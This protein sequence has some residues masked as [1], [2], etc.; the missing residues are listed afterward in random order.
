MKMF[1]ILI[2]V[3][4]SATPHPQGVNWLKSTLYFFPLK[5]LRALAPFN[6]DISG[7]VSDG[8][9]NKFTC[10]IKLQMLIVISLLFSFEAFSHN[11]NYQNIVLH[12]WSLNDNTKIKASFLMFKNEEVYLQKENAETVHFPLSQFSK[13]DQQNILQRYQRIGQLN[14]QKAKATQENSASENLSPLLKIV[15]VFL[16]LTLILCATYFLNSEKRMRYVS[17]F[18]VVAAASVIY[19]F[20]TKPVFQTMFATD[21]LSVDSAFAPFKPD[22]VTSWDSNYF[23]VESHGIPTTHPMMAGIVK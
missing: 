13:S 12:E 17:L 2:P 4:N 22:V 23:Y 10:V 18:A 1:S 11:I 8:K 7:G 15:S 14:W 21:P 19:S 3:R 16:I 9:K 20:K 6:P 5:G